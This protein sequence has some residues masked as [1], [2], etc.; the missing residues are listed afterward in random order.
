[1]T[2]C[3][4]TRLRQSLRGIAA[5]LQSCDAAQI[6]E[7]AVTLPLLMVFVVG[8]GDFGSAITLKQKLNNAVREGARFGA[9][10]PTADLY[11]TLAA[12]TAPASVNAIARLV[13]SYL[14]SARLN[15]CGLASGAWTISPPTAPLGWTYTGSSCA[16]TLNIDRGYAVPAGT[17]N[18]ST[19]WMISTRVT[20]SYPYAWQFNRVIGLIAPGANYAGP[21]LL[22]SDATIPNFM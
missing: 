19:K 8:I 20:I 6:I 2:S 5:R 7:F 13:G 3:R 12:N 9:N 15:D 10:E 14:Q 21:S 17:S 22:T 1:V 16:L 4:F 18:G 11:S